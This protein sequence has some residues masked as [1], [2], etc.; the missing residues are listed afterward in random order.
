MN[1]FSVSGNVGNIK[2][3]PSKDPAKEP[4]MIF[5]VADKVFWN[6]ETR[7]QWIN[8]K[9]FGKRV[10]GVRP[11]IRKGTFV[12]VH[13]RFDTTKYTDKDGVSR[14]AYSLIVDNLEFCNRE[15]INVD[16]APS[17]DGSVRPFDDEEKAPDT[18]DDDIP[19]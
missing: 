3:V 19:F 16:K 17:H 7:T 9:L 5:G 1:R 18:E 11:Y 12:A 15:K 13:G 6:G 8:C 10:A 4:F 14:E 2:I